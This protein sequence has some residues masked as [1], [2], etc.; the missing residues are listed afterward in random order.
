[1]TSLQHRMRMLKFT[2]ADERTNRDLAHTHEMLAEV[3]S[4]IADMSS[5]LEHRESAARI[6]DRFDKDI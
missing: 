4:G 6:I 2:P 1:M 5:A 3:Y